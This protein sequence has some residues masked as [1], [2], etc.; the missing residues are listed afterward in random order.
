[1]PVDA[2]VLPIVID[3]CPADIM[4][5]FHP[6]NIVDSEGASH[7]GG[8]FPF[9]GATDPA[10]ES[11]VQLDQNLPPSLLAHPAQPASDISAP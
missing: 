8:S 2:P 6:W 11:Q 3:I 9:F 7:L 5:P 10:N 1:M 4:V